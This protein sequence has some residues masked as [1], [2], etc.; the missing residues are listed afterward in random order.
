MWNY[1]EN[2]RKTILL[3][4]TEEDVMEEVAS[5]KIIHILCCR[6]I[7]FLTFFLRFPL[8]NIKSE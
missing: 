7:F 1:K 6:L 2:K 4:N 8:K 5:L 3:R